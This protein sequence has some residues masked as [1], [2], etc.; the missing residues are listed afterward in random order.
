MGSV[1]LHPIMKKINRE[2]RKI[3]KQ[4]R[5]GTSY[6]TDGAARCPYLAKS[7]NPPLRI[8]PSFLSML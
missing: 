1:T 3:C 8:A 6:Q 2:K 5:G 4:G 7:Q